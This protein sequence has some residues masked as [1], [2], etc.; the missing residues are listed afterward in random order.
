MDV[1]RND[2]MSK[3]CVGYMSYPGLN[4]NKS[5]KYKFFQMSITF[6]KP[7]MV[8]IRKLLKNCN[9]RVISLLMFYDNI[10]ITIFNMLD[11]INYLI[12]EKYICVGYLCLHQSQLS[13][14]HKIF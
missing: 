4:Q 8:S 5:F 10:N 6:D 2:K 12:M 7:T 11:P 9:T 13:L 14:E 3:F 1:V